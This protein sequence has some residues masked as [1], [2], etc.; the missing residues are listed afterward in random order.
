M[1][2][3]SQAQIPVEELQRRIQQAQV[4]TSE[5][6]SAV[7]GM[8]LTRSA[9][10]N[11]LQNVDRIRR[12]I[13]AEAWTDAALALMELDRRHKLRRLAFDDTEW[14]CTLGGQWPVPEWLDETVEVVHPVACLAILGALVEAMGSSSPATTSSVPRARPAASEVVASVSCDN[15]A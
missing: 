15:Y 12:L 13:H 9:A 8:I 7:L 10:P 1:W 6:V 4:V 3:H 2:P 5:L 14:H 11:R